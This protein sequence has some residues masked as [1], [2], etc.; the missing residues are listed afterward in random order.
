MN[1]VVTAKTENALQKLSV[2][3]SSRIRNRQIRKDSTDGRKTGKTVDKIRE[4]EAE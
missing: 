4:A 3:D 2:E 1:A